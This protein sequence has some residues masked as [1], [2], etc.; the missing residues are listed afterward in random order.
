MSLSDHQ[1]EF[2]IDLANLIKFAR[3]KGYKLTGGDL[4]RDPIRCNYGASNSKHHKRLAVD[5]NLFVWQKN[6][7]TGMWYWQYVTKTNWHRPLGEYWESLNELNRWGGRFSDG[8]H[9]ER[10]V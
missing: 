8:N 7:S 1:W 3:S 4:Y 9:Y 6:E 10:N 5:L 2:L